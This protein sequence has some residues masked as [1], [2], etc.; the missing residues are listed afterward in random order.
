MKAVI[1][2]PTYN[3]KGNI[4]TLIDQIE[5]EILPLS[6]YNFNLLI[7]DDSSPDKT[8]LVV[9]E[10][11]KNYPNLYLLIN[12]QKVGLGRALLAGMNYA[13]AKLGAEIVFEMDADLSHDPKKIPEFIKKIE[14]GADFVIGSRYIKGGSI[15]QRWGI[16]RKIFSRAGNLLVRVILGNFR[17]HEWTS[18]Y[19]AI[20]KKFFELAKDE[21]QDFSGYTFQVAFLHKSIKQGA[22]VAEVP[23]NF[24]ER[25]YGRS[26][27][28]PLDYITNL[29]LYVTTARFTEL[30]EKGFIKFC[31]VGTIGFIIN[32]L[33]LEVFYRLG[34]RPGPAAAM[35]AELAIISNFLLNNFWTFSTQR[36]T[37]PLKLIKKFLQ[38][39]FTSIGAVAI[40][41]IVVGL[42]TSFLGDEWRL[43][44]MTLA[45]VFLIIPYS[46]L[47]YNRV[48]WK[49]D[50]K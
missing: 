22:K 1:L 12:K 32:A 3:E 15:P 35:G 27:L 33:F 6:N 31:T 26:K 8:A 50:A 39:N 7:V 28:A 41:G 36:I 24:S 19:R 9:K 43:I 16:H 2:L 25:Y 13:F 30:W 49:T 10:K 20:K 11:Q 4:A 29:L 14:E 42:G 45:V 17:V 48:I 21:L 47:I 46:W 18:G 5:K 37:K 38:F 23:I 34:I 44:F 40:Q